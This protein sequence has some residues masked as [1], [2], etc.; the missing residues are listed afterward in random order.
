MTSVRI[1]ASALIPDVDYDTKPSIHTLR[2]QDCEIKI[3]SGMCLSWQNNVILSCVCRYDFNDFCHHYIN[4]PLDIY[5]MFL[6]LF[7]LNSGS[8]MLIQVAGKG[9]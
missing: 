5:C 8:F 7:H 4:K 6:Y 9:C 3:I 1:K 2:L